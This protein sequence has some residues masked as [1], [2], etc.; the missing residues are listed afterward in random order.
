MPD[1]HEQLVE[2]LEDLIAQLSQQTDI[3]SNATQIFAENVEK[4]AE[5]REKRR[6]AWFLV[7]V[8]SVVVGVF[9]LGFE[10]WERHY[11]R[12]IEIQQRV[13]KIEESQIFLKE[14]MVDRYE[15]DTKL[16]EMHRLR[17]Y[18]RGEVIKELEENLKKE[19]EKLHP[20]KE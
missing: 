18:E 19:I 16:L 10:T 13:I 9:I 7:V 17:D 12:L 11:D 3:R 2:E 8:T 1:N 5:E 15:F 20:R 14:H 4:R 6:W